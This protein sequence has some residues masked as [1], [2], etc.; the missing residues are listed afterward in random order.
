MTV[1]WFC[2]VVFRPV[3]KRECLGVQKSPAPI[4]DPGT[5]W[6]ILSVY[7]WKSDDTRGALSNPKVIT[8]RQVGDDCLE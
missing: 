4:Y 6:A 2:R 7:R 5:F 3:V 8:N 1:S